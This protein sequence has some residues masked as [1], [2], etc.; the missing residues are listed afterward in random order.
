MSRETS[1][2]KTVPVSGV[3]PIFHAIYLMGVSVALAAASTS[4]FQV[5][6]TFGLCYGTALWALIC[7]MSIGYVQ[8]RY[9]QPRNLRE[10]VL[11]Y[12]V[13]GLAPY[14][15]VRLWRDATMA[16]GWL[17]AAA[18]YAWGIGVRQ[19]AS[20]CREEVVKE[21]YPHHA[22]KILAGEVDLGMTKP[23]VV[24]AL[25]QPSRVSMEAEHD[26]V[27]SET[28]LYRR[29]LFKRLE[30]TLRDDVVAEIKRA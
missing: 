24:V 4:S 28:W 13:L 1:V 9:R 6:S 10:Q 2:L 20:G 12:L 17:A 27:R 25:R 22:E 26:G 14:V 23:M 11:L 18:F 3:E 7:L 15:G 16:G 30:V 21:L 8:Y 19:G 29:G 5:N